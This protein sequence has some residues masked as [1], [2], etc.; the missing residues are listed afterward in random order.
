MDFPVAFVLMHRTRGLYVPH[1]NF[2]YAVGEH[3]AG[4]ASPSWD[5]YYTADITLAKMWTTYKKIKPRLTEEAA[6]YF[7]IIGSDE[8]IVP[9]IELFK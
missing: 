8:S 5:T 1:T 2:G 6:K 9:A 4:N 3:I 7:D